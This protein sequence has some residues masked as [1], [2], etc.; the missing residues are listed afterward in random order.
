MKVL[1]QTKRSGIQVTHDGS[2]DSAFRLI[3][4]T[5]GW[6]MKWRRMKEFF[7]DCSFLK[8]SPRWPQL[9]KA[10][11]AAKTQRSQKLNK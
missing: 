4:E 9:E 10:R 3:H 1:E 8:S 11:A 5:V 6:W 2:R 7:S